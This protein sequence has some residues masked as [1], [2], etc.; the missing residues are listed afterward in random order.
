MNDI[1]GKTPPPEKIDS[2][3]KDDGKTSKRFGYDFRPLKGG[4]CEFLILGALTLHPL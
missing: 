1:M 2:K 4:T 3:I